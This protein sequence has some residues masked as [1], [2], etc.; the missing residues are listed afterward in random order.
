MLSHRGL[1][2]RWR[3]MT[4]VLVLPVLA[5]A[6]LFAAA[7]GSGFDPT[8]PDVPAE[9]LYRRRVYRRAE[10]LP[11]DAIL[12][13]RAS[14]DG[15]LWIGTSAGLVHY[16]GGAF[17][18]YDHVEHPEFVSDEVR[19]LDEGPDG[20]LWVGTADGL[21]EFRGGRVVRRWTQ[22]DGLIDASVYVVEACRDGSVWFGTRRAL[23]RIRNGRLKSWPDL[24]TEYSVRGVVNEIVED[25]DGV[26]HISP[27]RMPGL[28]SNPFQARSKSG[29][30]DWPG[31]GAVV[32]PAL[33]MVEDL[34][35]RLW[36]PARGIVREGGEWTPIQDPDVLRWPPGRAMLVDR[37]GSFWLNDWDDGLI[38][39]RGAR[40]RRYTR[41][42]GLPTTPVRAM[43]EDREGNLWIGTEAGLHRWQ[44]RSWAVPGQAEGL[45]EENVWTLAAAPSGDLWVGTDRGV[46]RI[47]ANGTVDLP[48]PGLTHP[49]VRSLHVDG[50]GTVWVGTGDSL[51]SL[52]GGVHS[53]H[54]WENETSMNKVRVIA[55]D[56]YG[57]VWVGRQRGLMCLVHGAWR[58]YSVVD[59]LPH[60]DV[61]ALRVDRFGNLWVGTAGG[62]VAVLRLED[63]A[64]VARN[65]LGW[66]VLARVDSRN[67]LPSGNAWVFLEDR[68]GTMWVGT[69]RGLARF[70]VSTDGSPVLSGTVGRRQGLH[71]DVINEIQEDNEGG[72]WLG[73]DRGLARVDS[74]ELHA[75]A[76]GRKAH[77]ESVVYSEAD[78]LPSGETNGQKSQPAAWK[79]PDGSLWFATTRGVLRVDPA[80]ARALATPV[81]A[82]LQRVVADGRTLFESGPGVSRS[83]VP[84]W[85]LRPGQG[86]VVE[87]SFDAVTFREPRDVRFRHR[88]SGVDSDWVE[89][90][91]RRVCYYTGLR[92]GT[93]RFEVEAGVNHGVW[94]GVPASFTLVL[95]P[96]LHQSAAFQ[97]FMLLAG[98][99]VLMLVIRWRERERERLADLRRQVELAQERQ[100]IARDMHDDLG[101]GLTRLVLL[102]DHAR[103]EAPPGAAPVLPALERVGGEAAKLVDQLGEL[104]WA[105]NPDFD[106]LSALLA[107]LRE[108]AAGFLQDANLVAD[109]DFPEPGTLPA[110]SVPGTTRKNLSMAFKEALNNAVRHAGARKV[111]VTC[112]V[113]SGR[114]EIV[115]VDDGRG[116]DTAPAGDVRSGSGGQGL[117][118]M[119]LRLERIGGT[120]DL[121]SEP[122]N[123]TRVTLVVPWDATE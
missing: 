88:L 44:P 87:V 53:V 63:P 55:S 110:R 43:L 2:Q 70:R 121:R 80:R 19:A 64:E 78:G 108:H 25:R 52:R 95:P 57:R 67:G 40:F 116:F 111:A 27:V 28:A 106:D 58:R 31:E 118:G 117:P 8:Q 42:D 41:N 6:D 46:R 120:F 112:R 107:R 69:E 51:E 56:A 82:V 12:A 65:D 93:Y 3:W 26:V 36:A 99:C 11:S 4:W 77:L 83:T 114:V 101:A 54:R 14:K 76:D 13:L 45:A 30:Y 48:L 66:A 79:A 123:G 49:N 73:T 122:G 105:T 97:G 20:S 10:G 94:G 22:A 15:S 85:K 9:V 81:P 37:H 62:G 86:R 5:Q 18:T 74:G 60:D 21:L 84:E 39:C 61:R 89:A 50:E 75:V 38:A 68:R 59:G 92:P 104:V 98:F 96:R 7:P 119:R 33:G 100:R 102:G 32:V 103:R 72:V 34:D 24:F 90:G 29:P 17:V 113:N 91:D 1:V 16:D 47:Q 115:I 109:L 23:H 35:G 71:Y